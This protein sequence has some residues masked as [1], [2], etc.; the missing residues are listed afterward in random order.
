MSNFHV[1]RRYGADSWGRK[2][3]VLQSYE[4]TCQESY[5]CWGNSGMPAIGVTNQ[6]LTDI[7]ASTTGKIHV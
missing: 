6:I 1:P 2:S 7:W 4:R 5:A 3:T